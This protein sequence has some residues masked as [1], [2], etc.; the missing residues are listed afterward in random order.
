[1]TD[2]EYNGLKN[3]D[4]GQFRTYR[5]ALACTVDILYFMEILSQ[6]L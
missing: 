5:L 4:D 2:E 1:M 6:M 3:A